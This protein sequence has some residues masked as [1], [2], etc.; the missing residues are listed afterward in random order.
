MGT[1][2]GGLRLGALVI[3]VLAVTAGVALATDAVESVVGADGT[4]QGC[5]AKANGQLRLV[6]SA[7]ECRPSELAV[8][9]SH[10]GPQ[11]DAGAQGP[12][13]PAGPQGG[14]GAQGV[15]GP[16]G[17]QGEKGIQGEKGDIG[18]PGDRGAQGLKGDQG[19]KGDQG[20]RGPAGPAG[21]TGDLASLDGETCTFGN[22]TGVYDVALNPNNGVQ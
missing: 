1:S 10:T 11:G 5:Y 16:Q 2:G 15:A 3:A 20:D 8:S 18:A 6:S 21:A 22:V 12:Q 7:V 4:M 13:G 9:W 14:R 19:P 17:V